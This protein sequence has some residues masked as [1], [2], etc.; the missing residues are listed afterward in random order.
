MEDIV[1]TCLRCKCHIF[2][3][4]LFGT[5]RSELWTASPRPACRRTRSVPSRKI[6][7]QHSLHPPVLGAGI[8]ISE[9]QIALLATIASELPVCPEK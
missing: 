4:I 3:W 2:S 8:F 1:R 5:L 9:F 6:A 7:G